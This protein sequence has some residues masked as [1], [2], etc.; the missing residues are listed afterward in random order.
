MDVWIDKIDGCINRWYK[1]DVW[2]IL[3]YWWCCCKLEQID[4]DGDD[5][6]LT[7]TLYKHHR[8]LELQRTT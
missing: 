2:I 3:L 4:D 5:S 1:I 6:G 8:V 7:T